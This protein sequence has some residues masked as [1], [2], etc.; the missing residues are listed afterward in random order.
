[1]VVTMDHLADEA[2]E[3]PDR[4]RFIHL[5]HTN[6]ALRDGAVRAEVKRRGFSVAEVGES[7]FL[8]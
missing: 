7:Y 8:D 5:N 6:P 2:R 3:G 4:F 1:M